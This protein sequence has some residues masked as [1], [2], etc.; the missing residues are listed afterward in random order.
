MEYKFVEEEMVSF[1]TE[2]E[3]QGVNK[4]SVEI[5][6]E[7]LDYATLAKIGGRKGFRKQILNTHASINLATPL[8]FGRPADPQ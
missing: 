2:E 4:D 3:L 6:E 1:E 5:E 8:F 7:E